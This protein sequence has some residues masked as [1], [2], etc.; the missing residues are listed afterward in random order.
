MADLKLRLK[1]EGD[2]KEKIITVSKDQFTIGRLPDCDLSLPLSQIS[3]YH[4]KFKKLEG[5]W[6]VEDLGSTNGTRLNDKAVTQT[7]QLNHGDIVQLGPI[8]VSILLN[9][10]Q[11]IQSSA[12]TQSPWDDEMTILRKAADLQEQWLMPNSESTSLA[13]Q[14][15]ALSRLK[16]L[17]DIAK[18]LNSAESLEAIF[19]QVQE[20]VFRNINTIER[21]A[22]LI[23]IKGTSQ[24]ELLNA[25]ARNSYE[26]KQIANDS[27]WI[28]RSICQKVFEQQVAI[29]TADA[30]TDQRFEGEHS[31][32]TKGI[33][34][35]L[36]VPLWNE[37]KV[38]GVLYGDAHL[39]F[40][41]WQ[42]GGEDDLSFFSALANLVGASVQR[43]LLSQK[44]T[45]EATIRHKLE[46]YHSPKVVEHMMGARELANGRI[47]PVERDISIMFADIVGFTALSERLTPKQIS[48]LLN[49]FFEEMLKEI[50]KVGGTLDKYIGDCIMAFFGAPEPIKDHADR[51]VTAAQGM[52]KRLKQ[53]NESKTLPEKLE[54]RIAINSGKA[55]VGDVGSSQRVDYTALGSTINLAS[56]MESICTPGQCVISQAT[57][58]LISYQKNFY[59]L[60]EYRFKGIER[61]VSVYQVK[62]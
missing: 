37:N 29:K 1:L 18:S 6:F 24:L 56:R 13:Y 8:F 55:I 38:V 49:A 30:Q 17:F 32:L 39:S 51:C 2:T 4:S 42:Q 52:L 15:T 57:Y 36:A 20:V 25:A 14:Q 53:L 34:S 50:F 27:T 21:L 61:P 10:H 28:S 47:I 23:D 62:V 58:D 48:D 60:G 26:Q 31:I 7:Q 11:Q 16:D 44:L 5:M 19:H 43:W 45:K 59:S 35:A 22:L 3:R 40:N 41:S 33:R 9:D 46:R 12:P 54:L